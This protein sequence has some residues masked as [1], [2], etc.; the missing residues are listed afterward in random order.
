MPGRDPSSD[1]LEPAIELEVLTESANDSLEQA[2]ELTVV[3]ESTQTSLPEA[4][5]AEEPPSATD[6][7]EPET[8]PTGVTESLLTPL[9]GSKPFLGEP[10]CVLWTPQEWFLYSLCA[11]VGNLLLLLLTGYYIQPVF[12][13]SGGVGFVA[14]GGMID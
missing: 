2:I 9:P 14:L 13:L 7:V 3:T 5:L 1:Y 10:P 4:T 6:F 11:A 8:E 12:T